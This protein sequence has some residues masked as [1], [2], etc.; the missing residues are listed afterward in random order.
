MQKVKNKLKKREEV[1]E[2]ATNEAEAE[3]ELEAKANDET[4]GGVKENLEYNA[5][6]AIHRKSQK[7]MWGPMFCLHQGDTTVIGI[8]MINLQTE[9]NCEEHEKHYDLGSL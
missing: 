7:R 8:G 2:E 9:Q 4:K 3:L 6:E 5:A 1:K